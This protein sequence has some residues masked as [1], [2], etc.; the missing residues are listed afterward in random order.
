VKEDLTSEQNAKE[1][2]D[3]AKKAAERAHLQLTD[4]LEDAKATIGKLEKSKKERKPIKSFSLRPPFLPRINIFCNQ[5]VSDELEALKED[6]ESLE[7]ENASLQQTKSRG[8]SETDD[9]ARQL[10]DETASRQKEEQAK[11]AEM[12]KVAALQAQVE[13]EAEKAAEAE[14]AKK[15]SLVGYLT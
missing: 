14:R 10:A 12:K 4:Q 11:K 9:L 5:S 8:Q 3:K 15:K 13:Q 2:T 1:S 6:V 7:S